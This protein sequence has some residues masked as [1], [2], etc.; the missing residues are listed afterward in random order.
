MS[1]ILVA[2]HIQQE[3]IPHLLR[4]L[5][6]GMDQLRSPQGPCLIARHESNCFSNH[7]YK[8]QNYIYIFI[9]KIQIGQIFYHNS[10]ANGIKSG[11]VQKR[12]IV[13]F[14]HHSKIKEKRNISSFGR[15]PQQFGKRIDLTAFVMLNDHLFPSFS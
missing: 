13:E 10:P 15:P 2:H 9:S 8:L 4:V 12:F 6:D 7:P 14:D 5:F 11:C 3:S 1:N